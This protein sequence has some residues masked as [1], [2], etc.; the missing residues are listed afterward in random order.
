M[1]LVD[2]NI[3]L[4]LINDDPEWRKWSASQITSLANSR[5]LWINV[6]IYTELLPAYSSE[7]KLKRFLRA[8]PLIRKPLP[9]S[10]GGP[11]ARA[12]A[13]YRR[14]G[15]VKTAPLPDFFIGAHAEA[16]GLTI[17]TRDA[18]RYRTYFPKVELICPS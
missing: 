5:E 3:I 2:T 15:G 10:A 9:Y 4:D 12:F 14:K 1:I 17:L 13:E 8:S 16:E 7:D 11:T 18:K 6:M